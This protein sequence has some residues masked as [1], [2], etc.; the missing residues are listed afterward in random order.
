MAGINKVLGGLKA[1]ADWFASTALGQKI[2]SMFTSVKETVVETGVAIN[3]ADFSF[4]GEID[5]LLNTGIK[6]VVRELLNF[7]NKTKNYI[8]EIKSDYST[9]L[10]INYTVS[11][12]E[13][14]I[15]F[16]RQS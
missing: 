8:N 6:S 4:K 5:E 15:D 9:N 14:I 3:S 1:M 12:E 7:D 2:M 16:C 11:R 13:T 10:N